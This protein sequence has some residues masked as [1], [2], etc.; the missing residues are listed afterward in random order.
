MNTPI[1]D[2]FAAIRARLLAIREAERNGMQTPEPVPLAAPG[3]AA[4]GGAPGDF[5]TWLVGGGL[6]ASG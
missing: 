5:Y 1:A 2:D 3:T 4:S 6:W